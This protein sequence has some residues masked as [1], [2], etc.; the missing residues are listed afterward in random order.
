MKKKIL[1]VISIALVLITAF[2][3][4]AVAANKT[5]TPIWRPKVTKISPTIN[6]VKID[7]EYEDEDFKILVY[8]KDA[9]DGSKWTRVGVTKPGAE[10]Y[11]DKTVKPNASYYY[12]IKAYYKANDAEKTEYLTKSSGDFLVTTNLAK[13]SFSLISNMGRG[14]VMEWKTR[15]DAS[16]FA[17]YRSLTGKKDSWTRIATINSGKE[18]KYIDKKV[19]IGDTY[20]YCFKAFKTIGNKT[21]YSAASKVHKK[22]ISGVTPPQN[23]KAVV[24]EDGV[25]ITYDKVPGVLGYSVYRREEGTDT[26]V[27]IFKTGSVNKLGCVDTTAE[28]GKV[29]TYTAKSYKTVN[30][31]TTSSKSA[32]DI[33]LINLVSAPEIAFNPA[34]ITFKDYYEKFEVSLS[35]ANFEKSDKPAIYVNGKLNADPDA[36]FS[37]EINEKKSDDKTLVLTVSRVK[38]GTGV[39][40]VEHPRYAVYAELKVNCPELAYDAD[41][42]VI[43]ENSKT[44]IEAA[45]NAANL[46]EES[47]TNAEKKA[48]LVENA[49]KQLNAAKTYLDVAE[50]AMDKY[51]KEYDKYSD[52][53]ADKKLVDDYA[54]AVEDAIDDLTGEAIADSNIRDAIR[55]LEAVK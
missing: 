36:V 48:T 29:Y 20:Y 33:K 2:S 50:T 8:R 35:L 41:I 23:F 6:S 10:T 22:V 38:P 1:S 14:I 4:F 24:K 16:G 15:N 28:K 21:Y 49:K 5:I 27:K 55:E 3:V 34:Q 13:P 25:Y 18:G 12:T 32:K 37:Y 45:K 43:E 39:L 19:N 44:G 47:L 9:K 53:K 46:L 7:F 26:W 54:D 40:K 17:I 52:Y 11:T 31:K 30:G 51:E 42:K